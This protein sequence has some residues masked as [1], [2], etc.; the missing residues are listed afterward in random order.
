MKILKPGDPCPCCGK[1]IKT[2]DLADLY[3]LSVLA[4][5]M[6]RHGLYPPEEDPE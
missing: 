2:K 6:E 4:E 1:P 5:W 3:T